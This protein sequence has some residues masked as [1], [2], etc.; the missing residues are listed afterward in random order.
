MPP[1]GLAAADFQRDLPEKLDAGVRSGLLRNLH[2]VLVWR[3]GGIALERVGLRTTL[4][5]SIAIVA[6]LTLIG[7]V[8]PAQRALRRP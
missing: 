7:F 6:I 2:S 5:G 1:P 4:P 3:S 8:R